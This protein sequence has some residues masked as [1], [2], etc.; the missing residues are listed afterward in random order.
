MPLTELGF[1]RPTYDELLQKQIERAKLL[2]GDD[3]DTGETTPFG[4]YIRINV[5]D[6]ADLYE[7]AE[8][9]YY[10]RFPNAAT[11][12]SLDRLCPFVGISRN[13]ATYARHKI[14]FHGTAVLTSNASGTYSPAVP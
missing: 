5:A 14:R 2:F 13:P 3:I 8:K 11:G 4:K 1:E 10:A 6:F 9:V 12:V 7:L